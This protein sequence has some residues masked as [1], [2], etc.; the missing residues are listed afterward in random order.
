V[1]SVFP[2]EYRAKDRFL[3]ILQLSKDE[4]GDTPKP[5]K[6]PLP[7]IH[8]NGFPG[9]G[10]LTI[11]RLVANMLNTETRTTTKLIHNHL[12]IDPTDAVLHRTQP[13]YQALRKAIRAAVFGALERETATHDSTY[14]FTD[15][16]S[17]NPEGSSVCAEYAAT[18]VQRG[19]ELVPIVLNCTVEENMRRLVSGGRTGSRKL[20]DVELARR[21]RKD[22]PPVHRF[23]GYSTFLELDVTT[24]NAEET[25]R[26]IVTHVLNVCPG[27]IGPK[28]ETVAV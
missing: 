5:I 10:K 17:S 27:V 15:W 6:I 14:I 20:T 9:T 7:I 28:L 22:G 26:V 16:Q 1:R 19:C 25:A 11:A 18:A 23:T 8:I 24:L 2:L 21:F 3:F 12:L 13:G 4:K